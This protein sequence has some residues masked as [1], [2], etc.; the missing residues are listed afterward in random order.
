MVMAAPQIT[1][2]AITCDVSH[3]CTSPAY[4]E[5]GECVP[6]FTSFGA[7][8]AIAGAGVAYWFIRSRKK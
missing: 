1:G 5:N 7:G 3:P 6:E 8:I 4:C 2:R